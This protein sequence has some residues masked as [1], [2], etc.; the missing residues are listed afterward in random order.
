MRL[1]RLH[2]A[3]FTDR[4]VAKF[5]L[6]VEGWRGSSERRR[7]IAR[8]G[9][10]ML[11]EIR[12]SSL[13][14]IDSSTLELGPGLTVITGETGAGKTMVVTALGLL[15][16]GRADT[17]AVRKGAA[18][19]PGRGRG[20]HRP[21][22]P[23]SPARS[24]KPGER[25]RTTGSC[26]PAT[27]PPR[28]ARGRSSAARRCPVSVL[29]EVAE[30]LVAVHGQSDQH[31][32][33][34]AR[35][36]REALDRFGGDEVAA[37]LADY[38]DLHE[39][40][41]ATERELDEVVAT[42]RERAREADLLRFGLGEIEAVS[43]EPG[44]DTALAAEEARLGFADELRNAAEQAREALSSDQDQPDA[45]ATT[46][47]AARTLLDGVR[48]HDAEAGELADRLAEISYL[49]SDVA[50]DVASYASR[51]ETDP[52][53]LAVV[54][55]RRAAL[56]ALTRKYGETIDE[57]LAWA[58]QSAARLTDL[59]DTDERIEELRAERRRPARAAGR[60]RVRAV[61]SPDRGG[62]PAR[63]RR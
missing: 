55:E 15:L 31:R 20:Q 12:I 27:S 29:A 11:E 48:D 36:Q 34:Q 39:R 7:R 43:P 19:R 4:L 59:D 25:S 21:T 45:L 6:P 28:A 33:L 62:G 41:L 38:T 53:R 1:V 10:R 51:L 37:L 8:A 14:V 44:E 32:L 3:P 40:L 61:R 54:S 49:L 13:G 2:E 57:V 18:D 23:A 52:A 58:E 42:A 26:W 47:A 46:S 16:G 63:R 60:C 17:G 5:G 9:A 50:A 22:W 30:P 35:A 24:R 56:T